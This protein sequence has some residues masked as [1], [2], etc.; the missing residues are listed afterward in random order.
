MSAFHIDAFI[1]FLAL[2]FLITA[3]VRVLISKSTK[4][5]QHV[6]WMR[7]RAKGT[8][9]KD[10]EAD[11]WLKL[12]NRPDYRSIWRWYYGEEWKKKHGKVSVVEEGDENKKRPFAR[13]LVHVN[14]VLAVMVVVVFLVSTFAGSINIPS[15]EIP[16][17]TSIKLLAAWNA[18][19]NYDS[20]SE[21]WLRMLPFTPTSEYVI[22]DI[23][24]SR[25]DSAM[26]SLG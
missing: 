8:L 10:L 20:E 7:R 15:T 5:I 6:I 22:F 1:V 16:T 4:F 24:L 9:L 18:T 3:V 17:K 2:A 26:C 12:I 25:T 19:I 14:I 23:L 13:K 11:Y 21:T